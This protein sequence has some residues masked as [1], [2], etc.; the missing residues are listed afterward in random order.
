MKHV[1][2]LCFF[3]LMPVSAWAADP[4]PRPI[5]MTAVLMGAD[6]K[7]MVDTTRVTPDDPKC[8]RCGSLTLGTVVS[9]ALLVDRKEDTTMDPVAKARRGILA[10]S[11]M[12]NKTAVLTASQVAEITK[13]M[14]VWPPLV[15]A[16]A[17]PLLDPNLNLAAQ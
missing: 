8:E 5:D 12:N 16:R 9:M 10:L 11:I 2:L 15:L 3:L 4:A 17:L 7:P 13:L 1:G 14:S 6:G